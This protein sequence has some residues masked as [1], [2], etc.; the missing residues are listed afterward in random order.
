MDQHK[1]QAIAWITRYI[2]NPYTLLARHMKNSANSNQVDELKRAAIAMDKSAFT[3]KYV[4]TNGVEVS[5]NAI[6]N[7]QATN[8]VHGFEDKKIS[9]Q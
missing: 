3:I 2:E 9:Q 5:V 7:N 8:E 1:G 6:I 4:S